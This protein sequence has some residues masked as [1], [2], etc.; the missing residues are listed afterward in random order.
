MTLTEA[1]QTVYRV[2]GEM[3]GLGLLEV[4]TY[5]QIGRLHTSEDETEAFRMLVNRFQEMFE[6]KE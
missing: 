6:P 3:G 1:F 2:R 4:L 5:Y